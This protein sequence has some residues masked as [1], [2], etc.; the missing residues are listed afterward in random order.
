[1]KFI[2]AW[3]FEIAAYSLIQGNVRGCVRSLFYFLSFIFCLANYAL[4][5][6]LFPAG[7]WAD[8]PV[9]AGIMLY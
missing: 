5:Y 7:E 6:Y 3:R 9:A 2:C 8:K 4:L 1:L